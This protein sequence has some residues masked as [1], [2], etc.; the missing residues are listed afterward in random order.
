MS[1]LHF[2]STKMQTPGLICNADCLRQSAYFQTIGNYLLF[3]LYDRLVFVHGAPETSGKSSGVRQLTGSMGIQPLRGSHEAALQRKSHC[4]CGGSSPAGGCPTSAA[5][6]RSFSSGRSSPLAATVAL[7]HRVVPD[8][9]VFSC[10]SSIIDSSIDVLL[11][12]NQN[13]V[14]GRY[15]KYYY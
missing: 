10:Q 3:V 5:G 4:N 14:I 13:P 11:L 6:S 12:Y 8:E 15:G 7:H 1:S 2:L 9:C